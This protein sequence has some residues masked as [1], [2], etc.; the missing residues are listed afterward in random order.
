MFLGFPG[1]SDGQESACHMGDLG[2]I[3]GLARS[4]GERNPFPPQYSG[5]GN[6]S[7]YSLWGRKEL[8]TA[9]QL[10]LVTLYECSYFFHL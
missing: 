9:K 2:L 5:L 1:G 7:D 10:S 4:P 3:P 6:C 8:D